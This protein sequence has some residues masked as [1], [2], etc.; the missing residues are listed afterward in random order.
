MH[1][2]NLPCSI[3]L[4]CF[5]D[6]SISRRNC[7]LQQAVCSNQ[8]TS[9]ASYNYPNAPCPS[10]SSVSCDAGLSNPQHRYQRQHKPDPN[11]PEQAQ[12]SQE[13]RAV[14][15]WAVTPPE[16]GAWTLHHFTESKLGQTA[17]PCPST[18]LCLL[19]FAKCL[20]PNLITILGKNITWHFTVQRWM[21]FALQYQ[22]LY[23][24]IALMMIIIINQ[25][26][27]NLTAKP[28]PRVWLIS[29]S[30]LRC[31]LSDSGFLKRGFQF[32]LA[33]QTTD[34]R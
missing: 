4:K 2:L 7:L 16:L 26:W 11:I 14:T 30:K 13:H 22:G 25:L 6:H 28:T 10:H 29:Q 5:S 21:T 33:H 20:P 15:H 17:P 32:P 9:E 3:I 31:K 12:Q 23:F 24:K 8:Y 34:L 27:S 1:T 19:S 18:T